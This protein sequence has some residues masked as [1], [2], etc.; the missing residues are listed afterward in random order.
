RFVL[1]FVPFF[2]PILATMLARW[3]PGYKRETDKFALNGVLMAGGVLVIVWYFPSRANLEQRIEKEFP[4]RAVNFLRS[5]PAQGPLFDNYGY[6]GY[7]IANLPEYKVFIDG[8]GDLY[9]L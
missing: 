9:E 2:A 4:V 6:G 1:L 7:L 8:R 3:L 5:H